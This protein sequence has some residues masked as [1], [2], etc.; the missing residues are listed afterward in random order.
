MSYATSTSKAGSILEF[1]QRE[2]ELHK[3]KYLQQT[4]GEVLSNPMST[5]IK[6]WD[7]RFATQG[8]YY[9]PIPIRKG[10]IIQIIEWCNTQFGKDHFSFAAGKIWFETE[11]AANWF[12]L[13]WS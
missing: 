9:V 12:V 1:V 7:K 3:Q 2:K 8:Y 6:D 5:G 11:K 4:V 10:S 13:R